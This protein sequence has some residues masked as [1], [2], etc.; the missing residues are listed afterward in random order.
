MIGRKRP[1]R[2]QL[3]TKNRGAIMTG[4]TSIDAT[5]PRGLERKQI[6]QLE[7]GMRGY[8]IR[9]DDATYDAARG[10][11]NGM[12]DRRP[13]LIVRCA[14][15]ADVINAVNFAREHEMPAS[16]RGGAVRFAERLVRLGRWLR[17]ES[18]QRRQRLTNRLVTRNDLLGEEVIMG[19]C[20]GQGKE[21]LL[22]PIAV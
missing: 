14:G 13:A 3:A 6:A 11:W 17:G 4:E 9:P 5:K 16:L 22:A 20:L 10:V 2:D 21:V 15:A 12:I 19:Q 1:D 8:L 7:A 18:W